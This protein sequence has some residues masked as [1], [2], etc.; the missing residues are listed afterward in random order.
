MI[1]IA[2]SILSADFSIL[3]DEVRAVE[4]AGADLIHCDVMDGHFVPNITIGPLIIRG[5]RPVTRLELDVHLMITDPDKYAPVFA[6]SGA[7]N[8]SF[9]PETSPDPGAL[10]VRLRGMRKR[11]GLVLN[12]DKPLGLVLP[13]LGHVQ[14]ILFMSVYPGFG[15]QK[16]MPEVL[17]KIRELADIVRQRKLDIDLEIDGGINR[18]T[19]AEAVRAGI[20]TL[21]AG[22]YVYDSED[23]AGRINSLRG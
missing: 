19:A 10:I 14:R 18:E 3:G 9:H 15:G 12:P 11:V 16:F 17:P 22:S 13:H 6:D 20:T 21:V 5:L 7:D 2:P 8:I 23:Y 4:A 1:K